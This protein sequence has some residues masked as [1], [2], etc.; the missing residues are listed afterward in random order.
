M[1]D[2]RTLWTRKK[3]FKSFV[4]IA[5]FLILF[6]S[7]FIPLYAITQNGAFVISNV[8][9]LAAGWL[10]GFR[11]GLFYWL[12]HSVLLMFLANTVG[13]SFDD[14]IS[15]GI[16]SFAASGILSDQVNLL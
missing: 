16:P 5:C 15:S 14:F 7:A 3:S 6:G 11:V 2:F 13:R 10:L 8:F 1:K 12:L 4:I 9:P